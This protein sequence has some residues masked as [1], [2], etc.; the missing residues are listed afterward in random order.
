MFMKKKD[1]VP[2]MKA[3]EINVSTRILSESA[4]PYYDDKVVDFDNNEVLL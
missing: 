3:H 1:L 2:E 4:L